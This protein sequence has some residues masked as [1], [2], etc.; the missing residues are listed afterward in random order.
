MPGENRSRSSSTSS[1]KTAPHN[2]YPWNPPNR[3][4]SPA[5]NSEAS[6]KTAEEVHY[7]WKGL[8][9]YPTGSPNRRSRG[10]SPAI[11]VSSD[12]SYK[13]AHPGY[14][15]R[16]A[17][18]RAESRLTQVSCVASTTPRG[19]TTRAQSRRAASG[20]Q[21]E[22]S[23]SQ[24]VT[25]GPYLSNPLTRSAAG[26]KPPTAQAERV[27]AGSQVSTPRAQRSTPQTRRTPSNRHSPSGGRDGFD[28]TGFDFDGLVGGHGDLN[29]DN[30]DW[31]NIDFG[32]PGSFGSQ[33]NFGTAQY[34]A[35]NSHRGT[36]NSRLDVDK[37]QGNDNWDLYEFPTFQNTS[38]ASGFLDSQAQNPGDIIHQGTFDFNDLGIGMPALAQGSS[39][40]GASIGERPGGNNRSTA[41]STRG[42]NTP[43]T[44]HERIIPSVEVPSA[45]HPGT[46]LE[47][48]REHSVRVP[49]SRHAGSDPRIDPT[50][51]NVKRILSNH[52]LDTEAKRRYE[53]FE[54]L[55]MC[56]EKNIEVQLY[57]LDGE[58][59]SSA[60][61]FCYRQDRKRLLEEEA[62]RVVD[63]NGLRTELDERTNPDL[64]DMKKKRERRTNVKRCKQRVALD[65][66]QSNGIRI[67]GSSPSGSPPNLP[68]HC[69]PEERELAE[70]QYTNKRN[71]RK[72]YNKNTKAIS[73][74]LKILDRQASTPRRSN[75]ENNRD[76]SLP[77]AGEIGRGG[78]SGVSGQGRPTARDP[79]RARGSA[80]VNPSGGGQGRT[81]QQPPPATNTASPRSSRQSAGDSPESVIVVATGR[82]PSVSVSSES[83]DMPVVLR[84]RAVR[85]TSAKQSASSTLSVPKVHNL[86]SSSRSTSSPPPPSQR[87][88]STA[89]SRTLRSAASSMVTDQATKRKGLK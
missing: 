57:T 41:A 13:S 12:A 81:K 75:I 80:G 62:M 29:F 47:G 63:R 82:R 43:R 70:Y 26:S 23:R 74:A 9:S 21:Q 30:I 65:I 11:T 39:S 15:P 84:R 50:V 76:G 71:N 28:Y 66:C 6:F 14:L 18:A 33:N 54:A 45:P 19:P 77:R 24:S 27:S 78:S 32:D 49:K 1:F 5:G 34:S 37:N 58:L 48:N 4:S 85:G 52:T 89:R 68:E 42:R 59:L 53:C 64:L 7:P 86:R 3:R 61:G 31:D 67:E 56:K 60:P 17:P 73:E 22:R 8:S 69:G 38:A 46:A 35:R 25:P 72:A 79:G 10:P 88:A 51:V 40:R 87:A 55:K 2:L 16:D 83:D 20:S 44:S 36:P